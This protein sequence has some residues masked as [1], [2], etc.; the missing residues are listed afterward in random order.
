MAEIDSIQAEQA[1][2]GSVLIDHG[3]LRRIGALLRE[4]D[5]AVELDRAIWRVLAE[6]DGEGRAIDGLTVAAALKDRGIG[7]DKEN[8]DYLAQLMYITPTSANA[9]EYAEIVRS[10]AVRRSVR[11]AL[12]DGLESLDGGAS[13]D[14]VAAMVEQQTQSAR[15]RGTSELISP[16]E[17]VERFFNYRER[18]DSG[19]K[20][21][22]STGFKGLDYKLGGGFFNGGL[23]FMAARPAMGKTALAIAIAE[24]AAKSGRVIFISLEMTGDQLTA[25]R[26]ASAARINSKTLLSEP[27]SYDEYRRLL[28][29]GEKI[30]GSGLEITDGCRYTASRICSIACSRPDVRLVVIDHFSLIQVPGKQANYIEYAN[31][32]GALKNLAKAINAP[33][34]CLAQ[35]NRGIENRSD[36]KPMLSDLRESGATE[37]DADGV[38]MLHRPDYYSDKP[39]EAPADPSSMDVILAKNRHGPTGKTILSYYKSTNT[40]REAYTK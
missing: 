17:Q 31:V 21:Y 27:L 16:S 39:D 15:Q 24:H 18:L 22:V 34:L 3:C 23:Y 10:T 40:F 8:R 35:M 4:E 38:L 2:L 28:E 5:F 6:M 30:K 26:M 32:S 36:K 7:Q 1:V 14:D 13:P 25:R 12:A 29:A 19:D 37:Q 11:R 20:P 9:E 33:V